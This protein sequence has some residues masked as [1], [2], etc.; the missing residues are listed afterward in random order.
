[1]PIS[2]HVSHH[3]A[4]WQAVSPV[5]GHPF[6]DAG[7]VSWN[8]LRDRKVAGRPMTFTKKMV[9]GTPLHSSLVPVSPP[10]RPPPPAGLRLRPR[11]THPDVRAGTGPEAGEGAGCLLG[12][13]RPL[14]RPSS[15][16]AVQVPALR[17][18]ALRGDAIREH[19]VPRRRHHEGAGGETEAG[20]MFVIMKVRG[21]ETEAGEMFVVMKARGEV[22][23]LSSPPPSGGQRDQGRLDVVLPAAAA[24]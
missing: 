1:M 15:S 7:V 11:A 20:E 19:D 24:L 8:E 14:P 12:C 5:D 16:D 3:P 4:A 10:R 17:R 21:E 6:L 13:L 23:A 2:P 18:R 22:P 9:R